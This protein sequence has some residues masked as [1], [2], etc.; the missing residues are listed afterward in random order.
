MLK[1]KQR[2]ID[3]LEKQ[4]RNFPESIFYYFLYLVSG[5]Y[6]LVVALRNFFYDGNFFSSYRAQ[7]RVISVGNLSWAGSGKTSLVIWL[8]NIF[9]GQLRTAVLRRG[10]GRDEGKLLSDAGCKVFSSPD[11]L[12]LAKELEPNFELFILDDAFQYRRLQRTVDIVVMGARDF[13][14]KPRLIPAY[15]FREPLTSLKRA[16][17]VVVNY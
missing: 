2:Y 10:Y 1:L 9:S 13:R 5:I 3:F 17:I 7:A 12:H 6:W 8:K 16:D 15:I 11:R 4:S 14:H